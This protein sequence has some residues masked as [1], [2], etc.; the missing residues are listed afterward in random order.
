MN[1]KKPFEVM[2]EKLISLKLRLKLFE[3]KG[4]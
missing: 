4:D 2:R 3:K 1:Y